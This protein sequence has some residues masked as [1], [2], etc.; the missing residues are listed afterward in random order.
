MWIKQY[1]QSHRCSNEWEADNTLVLSAFLSA[2]ELSLV[3]IAGHLY[4]LLDEN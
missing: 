4:G 1:E 3:P 2:N